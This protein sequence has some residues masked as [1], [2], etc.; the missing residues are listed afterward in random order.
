MPKIIFTS[1]TTAIRIIKVISEQ[2]LPTK[3]VQMDTT[4]KHELDFVFTISSILS[5]TKEN[6]EAQNKLSNFKCTKLKHI[7]EDTAMIVFSTNKTRSPKCVNI[8][9][10]IFT[11]PANQQLPSMH[12]GQTGMFLES[13][14]LPFSLTLIVRA[15][16]SRVTLVWAPQYVVDYKERICQIIEKHQVLW[17]QE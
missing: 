7:T 8:P 1:G 17:K 11:S 4:S 16:L 2:K 3:V 6:R 13:D 9:Y 12:R 15:I 5:N 10:T 14:N